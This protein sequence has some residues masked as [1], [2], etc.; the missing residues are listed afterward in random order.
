MPSTQSAPAALVRAANGATYALTMSPG[1]AAALLG[2]GRSAAYE[3][4]SAGTWPTPTTPASATTHRILT[5]PLL[6]Y[7]GISYEFVSAA[8]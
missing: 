2:L 4:V 5:L 6:A 7:A 3:M 8:P 1:A